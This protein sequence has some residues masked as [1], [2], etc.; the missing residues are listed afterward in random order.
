MRESG[1]AGCGYILGGRS[2]F[3]SGGDWQGCMMTRILVLLLALA[4]V[5]SAANRPEA[6]RQGLLLWYSFDEVSAAEALDR[7]GGRH[8]GRLIGDAKPVK[9]PGGGALA[10][11]GTGG[12]IDV[13]A[14]PDLAALAS[15]GTVEVWCRPQ[16]VQ[17]GL[18]NWS[19]GSG[20]PDERLVLAVNTYHGNPGLLVTLADGASFQQVTGFGDLHPG[21]WTHLAVTFEGTSVCCYRDGLLANSTLQTVTPDLRGVPLWIGRCQGLGKEYFRGLVDEVRLYRRALSAGEVFASYRR[22][23]VRHGRDPAY[24]TRPLVQARSYPGPGQLVVRVDARVLQPLPTGA[25]VVAALRR[26]DARKSSRRRQ[27][28]IDHA[29][30]PV[31][32]SFSAADLSPGTYQVTAAV[33]DSAGAPLGKPATARVRWTG[34]PAGMKDIR[35]LNNLTWELL[36]VG[37][38][39][40]SRRK[41]TF[42]FRQPYDRWMFLHVTAAPTPSAR[43]EL[44]LDDRKKPILTARGRTID[45]AESMRPLAAGEHLLTVRRTGAVRL[46]SLVVRSVPMLQYAFYGANPHVKPYGPYDWD[47]LKTDVLP[48]VNVILGPPG[49]ELP[50]WKESGRWWMGLVGLPPVRGAGAAATDSAFRHWTTSPGYRNPL[51]DGVIV[52]EFG[53]GDDPSYDGYR[54]AVQRLNTD[55]HFAGKVFIPYGG[56]F[57]TPDRSRRFAR[58]VLAGGGYIA[59]ERYLREQPTEVAAHR[60]LQALAEEMQRWEEGLPGVT[61]RMII[62]LG[63]MSQPTESLNVD[64]AVNYRV[65]MDRQFR[66]LSTHPAFFALGGIQEYHSAYADEETVRWAGR[67]YRHYVLDGGTTPLTTDPYVLSH[68]KNPDFAQATT[69]WTLQPAEPDSMGVRSHPGLSWLEGRYPPTPQGNTFLWTRRSAVRPNSF[70]QTL[71]EL[72][73]GK[74]YSLKMITADYQDLLHGRARKATDAVRIHLDRVDLLA[75]PARS[76]QFTFPNCY[77]H[78]FGKFNATHSFWMNYHYRVFRAR[79][80]TARLTVSDWQSETTPGGPAGQELLYNFLEVQPY[81]GE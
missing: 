15:A 55:P 32:V 72:T 39:G 56:R 20:W 65:W 45:G 9:I 12:Y 75:G 46:R 37:A 3:C 26:R 5:A 27:V 71:K 11:T 50:A 10:L 23:A 69:G 59:W 21:T 30:S 6:G 25:V 78:R 61:R 76:F 38:A 8:N 13:G 42:R 1:P 19:T 18:V 40:Q 53:G 36:H 4:S 52:D 81:L 35:V 77:S 34:Q 2:L 64:P 17:G 47:F 24:F 43:L 16:A 29:T 73:P 58:A 7:S 80:T 62:V 54:K 14:S 79:A 49:P 48:N 22:Q 67:L 57:Y 63:Y 44:F 74:L 41:K 66:L 28:R 60:Q 31:D 51:M 70:T 33:L 68:L